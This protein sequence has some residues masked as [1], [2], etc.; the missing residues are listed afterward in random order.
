MDK[1]FRVDY[2]DRTLDGY[3]D[4]VQS[5]IVS[6]TSRENCERIFEDMYGVEVINVEEV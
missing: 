1:Q 4:G 3:G 6:G 5:D 2:I